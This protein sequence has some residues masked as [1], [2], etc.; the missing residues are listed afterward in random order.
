MFE[1]MRAVV[2]QQKMSCDDAL[3]MA[4]IEGARALGLEKDLGSLEAGKRADFLVVRIADVIEPVKE[5]VSRAK[6]N[7][8]VGTF[9]GGREARVEVEELQD[10]VRRVQMQLRG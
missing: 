9:L 1:E 5:L 7:D 2:E 8:I 3:R 6:V 4:T 10:E